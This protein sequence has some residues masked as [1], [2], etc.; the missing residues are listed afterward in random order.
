MTVNKKTYTEEEIVRGCAGN[1]RRFQEV[2]Y[3]RYF[4]TML[5]MVRRYTTEEDRCVEILNDGFLKVFRKIHTF[6]FEGSLEGWIRR[7]VYHS[8]SDYFRKESAY[9]RFIVLE[10]GEQDD[11]RSALDELFYD[12]LLQVVEMLPDRSRDV[13]TLYAIEGYSHREIGERLSMSE[14]TSKW[15]L[16]NARKQLKVLLANKLKNHYAG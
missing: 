4:D 14:G 1:E 10:D 5:R 7:I 15:H 2:L 12:D 13:F 11:N 8:I 6:R 9:L 3:R 16:S